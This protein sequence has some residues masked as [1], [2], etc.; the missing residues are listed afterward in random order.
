MSQAYITESYLEDIADAIREILNTE[1]T[2]LPSEMPDA[3]R[4]IAHMGRFIWNQYCIYSNK[5]LSSSG[6]VDDSGTKSMTKNAGSWD[7]QNESLV[8]DGNNRFSFSVPKSE[9]LIGFK[10]TVASNWTPSSSSNWFESSCIV[11]REL[12]SQQR[13][14]A[15]LIR[16]GLI[17]AMGYGYSSITTGT[18]SIS[19]DTETTIF[20]MNTSSEF[21]LWVNGNLS[22]S[23]NYTASGNNLSN[24]GLF[25]N[26]DN[27]KGI[28]KGSC[29]KIGIWTFSEFDPSAEIILPRN[30]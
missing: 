11:G 18:E 10:G 5:G 27:T 20:M 17:P 24:M 22:A 15:V 3:I 30:F 21:K 28:F 23:V 2:Y 7:I 4:S 9:I 26:G 14:W 1:D 25:W 8:T 29:S 12:S 6:W 13:D 16:P 19:A